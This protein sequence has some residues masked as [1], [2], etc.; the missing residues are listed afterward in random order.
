VAN[1]NHSINYVEF[2]LADPAA[3]KTFYT[4]AFGWAF[5]DWGPD[6]ISFAGAGVEG[7]FNRES[8]VLPGAPGVLVILYANDLALTEQ[9]IVEAGG[10]IST[11][12]YV[13]P[14]GRRFHFKDPNGNELAVWSER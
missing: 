3:T 13:F 1:I 2:P 11:P 4:T 7:G 8:G 9:R 12:A 14:G 6:Y 5:T 10:T